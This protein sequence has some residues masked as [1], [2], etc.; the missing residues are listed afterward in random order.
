MT[1]I[2][3]SRSRERAFG[4]GAQSRL[5]FDPPLLNRCGG[6]P[7]FRRASLAT[8]SRRAELSNWFIVVKPVFA[9]SKAWPDL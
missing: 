8:S 4:K 7:Y 5:P 6:L 2:R 9:S 3:C 1:G